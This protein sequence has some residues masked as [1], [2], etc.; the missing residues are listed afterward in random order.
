[1]GKT[2]PKKPNVFWAF[3]LERSVLGHAVDAAL[4]VAQTC[5]IRGYT[6]LAIP[7][8]RTDMARNRIVS[9]F[10]EIST[11][12]EDTLIML[13]GDHA[14]PSDIVAR[15]ACYPKE[16]GVIGALYF[17]RGPPYDPLFFE[18]CDGRLRNPAEWQDG[19]VYEVD[20]VATGAIAIKRWVFEK[21]TE[22]GL[23]NPPFQYRYPEAANWNQTEDIF[24]AE[25]CRQAGIKHH[26]D[27]GIKTPHLSIKFVTEQ[28]WFDHLDAHPEM[29]QET[30]KGE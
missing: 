14:H 27:T 4:D 1:M 15:L 2:E 23:G 8:S 24:F 3:L 21:L 19:M 6:R 20:A 30:R 22:L 12:P 17:R 10:M 11:G 29:I 26:C 25:I 7:Y 16:I 5:A 18:F 13:D 9:A 28:D